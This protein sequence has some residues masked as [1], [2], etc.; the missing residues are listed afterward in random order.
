MG[1]LDIVCVLLQYGASVRCTDRRT[2]LTAWLLAASNG[3]LSVLKRLLEQPNIDINQSDKN[4]NTA[5]FKAT[6][7]GHVDIVQWLL[8]IGASVEVKNAVR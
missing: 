3:H 6:E 2:G 7:N 5:V 1:H 4:G 8:E